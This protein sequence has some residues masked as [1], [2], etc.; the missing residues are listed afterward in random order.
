MSN[1]RKMVLKALVVG[2]L[3]SY[4]LATTPAVAEAASPD[5]CIQCVEGTGCGLEE[6]LCLAWGCNVG[7][8]TCG[9]LG[10]CTLANGKLLIVCNGI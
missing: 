2:A 7:Q 4:A 3:G 10:D 8:A 5:A 6:A 9:E 1:E